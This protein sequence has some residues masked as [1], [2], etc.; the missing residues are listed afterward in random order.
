MMKSF[1]GPLRRFVDWDLSRGP[2]VG[3]GNLTILIAITPWAGLLAF[4]KSMS[5]AMEAVGLTAASIATVIW[6]AFVCWRGW[7]LMRATG[8]RGD[9]AYD[10][11]GKLNL[12]SDY[13][14]SEST[15]K[16][17]RRRNAP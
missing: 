2:S 6:L 15:T 12:S 4:R 7:R 11:E 5:E 3:T 13:L 16:A 10:R 14:K 8:I 17:G 9:R 1:F